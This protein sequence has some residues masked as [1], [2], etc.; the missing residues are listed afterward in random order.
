M[1][2][3][4]TDEEWCRACVEAYSTNGMV[5]SLSFR[6]EDFLKF[7]VTSEE[8]DGKG[9]AAHML[10]ETYPYFAGRPESVQL[11]SFAEKDGE[12]RVLDA[13]GQIVI[14][15]QLTAVFATTPGA[16]SFSAA[17][18]DC[19]SDESGSLQGWCVTVSD[20]K[21]EFW[22]AM[23]DADLE[24]E[25]LGMVM[26]PFPRLNVEASPFAGSRVLL[27]GHALRVLATEEAF[28]ET[29]HRDVLR[30]STGS[31]C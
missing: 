26:P 13:D 27:H 6:A 11:A 10:R 7:S 12:R 29:A 28:W 2:K 17:E 20:G 24:P 16:F 14:D 15:R 22:L 9:V 25:C 8:P 1:A 18:R 5:L 19:L 4:L 31:R 23:P 3:E 30:Y 21:R